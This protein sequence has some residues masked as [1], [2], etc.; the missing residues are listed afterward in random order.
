MIKVEKGQFLVRLKGRINNSL[1]KLKALFVKVMNFFENFK[2]KIM[3]RR[4]EDSFK[5]R[6][7]NYD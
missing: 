6:T 5:D 1:K 4:L 2:V 7:I 3:K